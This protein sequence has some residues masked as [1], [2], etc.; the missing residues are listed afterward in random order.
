[1]EYAGEHCD[2]IPL[3]QVDFNVS[4]IV[5]THG[6]PGDCFFQCVSFA[7]E[8][9]F[10]KTAF[11]RLEIV[12]YVFDHWGEFEL[13][14]L[15]THGISCKHEYWLA[16]ATTTKYAESSEIQAA[17]RILGR[18]INVWLEGEVLNEELNKRRRTL[19]K[20]PFSCNRIDHG[21]SIEMLL[22]HNHFQLMTST[23]TGIGCVPA[24]ASR[25]AGH[26]PPVADPSVSHQVTEQ[27]SST[28]MGCVPADASMP[29]T[30]PPTGCVPAAP[31]RAGHVPPA[32][33]ADESVPA[34]AP[35]ASIPILIQ[36]SK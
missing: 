28:G 26:I 23:G 25:A 3:S 13:V 31:T 4:N 8:G 5:P 29:T 34:A 21:P 27:A 33:Q 15:D 22:A 10:S 6:Q 19:V 7:V 9:N 30:A 12:R 11:Y 32:A 16:M 24:A 14:V 2:A 20:T 35:R 18:P 1:M 17:A 36:T